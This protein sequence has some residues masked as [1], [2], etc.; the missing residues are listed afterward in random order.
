MKNLLNIE[1]RP[2]NTDTLD[3]QIELMNVAF[4]GNPDKSPTRTSMTH[5]H[6][7]NPRKVGEVGFGAFYEDKLV[8]MSFFIADKFIYQGE[9]FTAVQGSDA[10]IHPDFQRKGIQTHFVQMAE[11]YYTS[12]GVDFFWGAPNKKNY[13]LHIKRGF[14]S[15]EG[16]KHIYFLLNPLVLAKHFILKKQSVAECSLNMPY[17]RTFKHGRYKGFSFSTSCQPEDCFFDN[18]SSEKYISVL[19]D[20]EYFKWKL[21]GN[22]ILF[23]VVRDSQKSP[24]AKFAIKNDG[25]H[26]KVILH[27]FYSDNIAVQKKAVSL[28]MHEI[29]KKKQCSV[30]SFL[31]R[32]PYDWKVLKKCGGITYEKST[33]QQF[34]VLKILTENSGKKKILSDLSLWNLQRLE[35]DMTIDNFDASK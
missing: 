35:E 31:T 20:K 18:Y 3:E 8:G 33:A 30:M 19:C 28:L 10:A 13:G 14:V 34:Y 29:R 1:Y 32:R 17:T 4:C 12:L 5:K 6:F 23:C 27:T 7:D 26:A 22:K 16:G 15:V 25:I 2:L 11:E 21:N 9:T 24:V